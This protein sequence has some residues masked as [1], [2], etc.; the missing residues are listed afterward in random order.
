MSCPRAR[1]NI[2]QKPL[3]SYE[4]CQIQRLHVTARCIRDTPVMRRG[5]ESLGTKMPR[6]THARTAARA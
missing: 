2:V 3:D 5:R 6:G 1:A 4:F